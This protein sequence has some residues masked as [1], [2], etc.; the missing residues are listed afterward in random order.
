VVQKVTEYECSAVCPQNMV[1]TGRG[2]GTIP[3]N[4]EITSKTL[5][6]LFAGKVGFSST[7]QTSNIEGRQVQEGA[8]AS[9]LPREARG[10]PA[11][12]VDQVTAITRAG[13]SGS[14]AGPPAPPKAD[15]ARTPTINQGLFE[16]LNKYQEDQRA[17]GIITYADEYSIEID[18]VLADARVVPPGQINKSYTAMNTGQTARDKKDPATNRV[19]NTTK[20]TS[21]I[22]G[23]SIVQF[24]DQYTRTSTYI[25]DQ[26]IV[27]YDPKTGNPVVSPS[28]PGQVLAWYHIGLQAEPKLDQWD[29]KRNDYAY[30][31]KFSLTPY[32]VNDLKSDYFPQGRYQGAHKAYD[33]WFTGQNSQIINFEQDFNYLYYLVINN[34]IPTQL[35]GQ[36]TSYDQ[37]KDEIR[38]YYQPRSDQ[39]SQGQDKEVNEPSANAADY[40]YSPADQARVKMTIIGDPSWIQQGELWQGVSGTG[41]GQAFLPDGTISYDNRE[42]LFQIAFNM[43]TDYDLGTGLMDVGANNLD[44]NRSQNIPGRARQSYIYRAITCTSDFSQGK[45]T[46]ELEGVL[47]QFDLPRATP[48]SAA[49]SGAE[50]NP[51]RESQATAASNTTN[52]N[53]TGAL[54]AGNGVDFSG[55]EFG[56]YFGSGET[57]G[58]VN[59]NPRGLST[60]LD[61]PRPLI[62]DSIGAEGFGAEALGIGETTPPTSSGIVIEPLSSA[63]SS[64]TPGSAPPITPI[65]QETSEQLELKALNKQLDQAI[66][67]GN[68][69]EIAR[70]NTKI[71]DVTAKSLRDNPPAPSTQSQQVVKDR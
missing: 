2:R 24:I 4:V 66:S 38:R 57:G 8:T 5:R 58:A 59:Y 64:A 10:V 71:R 1:N 40:L 12:A 36:T 22:A 42:I 70:L 65:T 23:M 33:F 41:Y 56:A 9:G 50:P 16:A 14:T 55:S 49:V 37:Y 7:Q 19:D 21:A 25:Y 20:N 51:R 60:V 35:T 30:R 43:P 29:P 67:R 32:Q 61:S 44:A 17:A 46:Q 48:A 39:S 54:G 52:S 62:T 27:S 6:D 68:T 47:I 26:Q 11:S 13:V 15:A 45:F 28:V 53:R 3:Y 34:P 69:A 63:R 18:P 31:I